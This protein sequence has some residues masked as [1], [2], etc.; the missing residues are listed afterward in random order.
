VVVREV[1]AFIRAQCGAASIDNPVI[2]KL[3]GIVAEARRK[4]ALMHMTQWQQGA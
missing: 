1:P 2:A 4:Q 3:E